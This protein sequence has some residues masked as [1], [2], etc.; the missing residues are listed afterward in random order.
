MNLGRLEALFYIFFICGLK[1]IE[2]DFSF[3]QSLFAPLTTIF[4][5]AT[6]S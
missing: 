1:N 5:S 4:I 3:F 6:T 2:N